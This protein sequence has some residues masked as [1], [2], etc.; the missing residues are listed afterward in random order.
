MFLLYYYSDLKDEEYIEVA[1]APLTNGQT[2]QAH[3]VHGTTYIVVAEKHADFKEYPTHGSGVYI[4]NADESL[5]KI[6]T[7]EV[8]YPTDI[9]IW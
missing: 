5:S 3:T 4:F 6:Q 7:L 1:H 2:L 8:S 9:A